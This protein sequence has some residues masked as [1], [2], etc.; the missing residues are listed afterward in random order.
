MKQRLNLHLYLPINLN[1]APESSHFSQNGWQEWWLATAYL[2][3]YNGKFTYKEMTEHEIHFTYTYFDLALLLLFK[4]HQHEQPLTIHLFYT[5]SYKI[6]SIYKRVSWCHTFLLFASLS[7]T[8]ASNQTKQF[9]KI[10]QH[11]THN[12]S[13]TS[14]QAETNLHSADWLMWV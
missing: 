10:V 1:C 3:Y 4:F 14:V 12:A 7:Q 2:A 6:C 11:F 13:V 8:H 5:L 9:T